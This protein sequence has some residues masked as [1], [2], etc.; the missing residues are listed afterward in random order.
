MKPVRQELSSAESAL[1]PVESCPI[2]SLR[3]SPVPL[4]R[5]HL[6]WSDQHQY[7][8]DKDYTNVVLIFGFLVLNEKLQSLFPN[9]GLGVTTTSMALLGFLIIRIGT[10]FLGII[11]LTNHLGFAMSPDDGHAI[12]GITDVT[13]FVGKIRIRLLK[14]KGL[15]KLRA[16]YKKKRLRTLIF[17]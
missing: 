10:F 4:Q 5:F 7:K 11:R 12:F 16:G 13:N 3:S 8:C 9:L 14:E 15:M 2:Q 6:L 1:S 17:R